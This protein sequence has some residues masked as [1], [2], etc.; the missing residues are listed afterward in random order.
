[1]NKRIIE[2]KIDY[3]VYDGSLFSALGGYLFTFI[4]III[5]IF[6]VSLIVISIFIF[7]FIVISIFIS[8]FTVISIFNYVEVVSPS[9]LE[10]PS[11]VSLRSL[12]CSLTSLETSS[13]ECLEESLEGQQIL[14]EELVFF[15][16]VLA[17]LK[18]TLVIEPVSQL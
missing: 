15:L 9:G 6:I 8:I 17:S 2:D 7:I 10:S 12:S 13:T 11:P 14:F 5:C 4:F 3:A 1:M 16:R 18:S